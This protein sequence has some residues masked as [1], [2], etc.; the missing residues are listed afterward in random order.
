M[1]KSLPLGKELS[2][3]VWH[4]MKIGRDFPCLDLFKLT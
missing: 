4:V 3:I 1:V 2:F